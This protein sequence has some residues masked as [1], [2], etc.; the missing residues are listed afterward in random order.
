MDYDLNPAYAGTDGADGAEKHRRLLDT[1]V[2]PWFCRASFVGG[3]MRGAHGVAIN[4]RLFPQPGEADGR[5]RGAVV[6]LTGWGEAFVKYAQ[7]IMELYEAGFSVYTY[8]HRSQGSSGRPSGLPH[9]TQLSHVD[10][11]HEYVR[12]FMARFQTRN[13]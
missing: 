11:F 12:D 4:Y 1:V 2:A 9:P 10:D 3:R 13:M 7:L 8:D 6:F 5:D